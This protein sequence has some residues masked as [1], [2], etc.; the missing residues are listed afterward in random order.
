MAKSKR[1][2]EQS[3]PFYVILSI[4]NCTI[5]SKINT[6][7]VKHLVVRLKDTQLISER[8]FYQQPVKHNC[9]HLNVSVFLSTLPQECYR[10]SHLE[11]KGQLSGGHGSI[12]STTNRITLLM[13]WWLT[14]QQQQFSR[15]HFWER[16]SP[17]RENVHCPLSIQTELFS[18]QHKPYH[19][20][21][22]VVLKGFCQMAI[23][24]TKLCIS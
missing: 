7:I 19:M 5:Q 11:L 21:L 24:K 17:T 23:W 3:L 13:Y 8:H 9:L 1:V 4:N 10:Q 15:L 12:T 2:W 14:L 6:E 18:S 16:A 22:H 20:Y